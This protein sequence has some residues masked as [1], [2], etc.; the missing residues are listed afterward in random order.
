MPEN[1]AST[2]LKPRKRSKSYH[3]SLF[4]SITSKETGYKT[5]LSWTP[6]PGADNQV[7]LL[8][9]ERLNHPSVASARRVHLCV[10][11]SPSDGTG[12]HPLTLQTNDPAF[13]LID[14][15]RSFCAVPPKRPPTVRSV[16]RY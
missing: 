8:T 10:R 5:Q 15:A 9:R 3:R 11:G 1:E 12:G 14:T 6:K 16:S 13:F 4:L 7:L 2:T